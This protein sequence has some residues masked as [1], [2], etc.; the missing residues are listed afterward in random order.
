MVMIMLVL[1]MK[2]ATTLMILIEV[3]CH[4]DYHDDHDDC[5]YHEGS[6]NGHDVADG[7]CGSDGEDDNGNEGDDHH[8]DVNND[9]HTDIYI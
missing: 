6:A 3:D 9:Q 5:D 8:D 7:D 4:D 2:K 1:R